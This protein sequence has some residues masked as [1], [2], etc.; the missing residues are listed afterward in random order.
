MKLYV[1]RKTESRNNDYLSL[2]FKL[3]HVQKVEIQLQTNVHTYTAV[4]LCPHPPL[5]LCLQHTM[6]NRT[7]N[8]PLWDH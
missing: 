1:P 3:L 8:N 4:Q 7:I 2:I 6:N 5:H